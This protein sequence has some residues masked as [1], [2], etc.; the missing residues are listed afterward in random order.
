MSVCASWWVHGWPVW[1]GVGHE[2][3]QRAHR[4]PSSFRNAAADNA[5]EGAKQF[6][7]NDQST[8]ESRNGLLGQ[9]MIRP[10]HWQISVSQTSG[11]PFLGGFQCRNYAFKDVPQRHTG[12]MKDELETDEWVHLGEV[13]FIVCGNF[14][15]AG[16][17]RHLG[18]GFCLRNAC[19]S[20]RCPVDLWKHCTGNTIELLFPSIREQPHTACLSGSTGQLPGYIPSEIHVNAN[21]HS[22]M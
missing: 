5:V 10:S 21:T 4:G 14:V 3:Q 6:E 16:M 19:F 22:L 11:Q 17:I 12:T 7:G 1:W 9:S 2:P 8:T 18:E 20:C 15:N 13:G